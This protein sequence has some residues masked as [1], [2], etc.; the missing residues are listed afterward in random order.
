MQSVSADLAHFLDS[1]S[2]EALVEA[3]LRREARQPGAL[4]PD[5]ELHRRVMGAVER[6]LMRIVHEH[7]NGNQVHSAAILG[8]NRTT[9]RKKMHQ[10]EVIVCRPL[11]GFTARGQDKGPGLNLPS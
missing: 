3:K 2:L 4:A 11:A 7:T 9:V 10:H 6:P 5:R 8:L 1:F